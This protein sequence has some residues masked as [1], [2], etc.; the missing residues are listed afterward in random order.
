M[1]KDEKEVKMP[2]GKLSECCN[3]DLLKYDKNWD[4]GICSKCMEHSPAIKNN[5]NKNEKQTK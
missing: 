2:Y 1:K 5:D 3:A 4:D